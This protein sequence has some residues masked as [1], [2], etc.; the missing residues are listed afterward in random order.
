MKKDGYYSSG[1]FARMA[2]VT[3]RT[4][5]YYDKKNILKPSYIT[6]AGA[7]FYTDEDF[8]KLQQILLLKYLGFSLDDIRDM[9]IDDA[10]YHFMLNSLNIQLKLV[11]DRI[12]QM[13]VVEQAIQETSDLIRKEHSIDW[14]R[15]LNLIHLTGMEKSMKNQ[16]QDA[17]NISARINL[18]S[19]YSENKK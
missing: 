18:H 6:E 19:L 12:E 15:M 8:A 1:E 10:D 7:R 13:Q 9:T 11:R 14:S 16:Y 5:R 17:S 3:L 4:I 2:Q